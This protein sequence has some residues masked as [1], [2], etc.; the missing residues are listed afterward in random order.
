VNKYGV[1][2]ELWPEPFPGTAEALDAYSPT[3]PRLYQPPRK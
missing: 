3:Y 1:G 2:G